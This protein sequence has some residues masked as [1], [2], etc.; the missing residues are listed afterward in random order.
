MS[1]R[2]PV[3]SILILADALGVRDIAE[4]PG[5]WVH[6]LDDVWTVAVNGQKTSVATEPDGCM[7]WTLAPFEFAV[8]YNGFLA[9][10]MAVTGGGVF[11]G[12]TGANP[13]EFSDVVDCMVA[14]IKA[15]GADDG[16]PITE[17]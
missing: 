5:A 12:G 10:A 17:G 13:Q 4:L 16:I 11:A 9:G 8:W 1:E 2:H 3:K 6:K 15:K 14:E 7:A